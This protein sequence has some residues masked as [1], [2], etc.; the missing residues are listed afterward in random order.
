M[1]LATTPQA[2][3]SRSPAMK[4][5]RQAGCRHGNICGLGLLLKNAW[6]LTDG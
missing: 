2:W 6:V 5:L 3:T 4:H 1:P